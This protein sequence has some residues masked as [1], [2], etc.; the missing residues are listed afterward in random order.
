MK[1]GKFVPI[2]EADSEKYVKSTKIINKK[3]L[4]EE[5]MFMSKNVDIVNIFT[6]RKQK[7][8][9]KQMVERKETSINLE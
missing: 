6:L 1:D 2:S 9:L 3:M 8:T 7:K 5:N 4:I